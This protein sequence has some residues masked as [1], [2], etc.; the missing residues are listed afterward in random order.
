[1][2]VRPVRSVAI[3]NPLA[4]F[5]INQYSHELAEALGG[6]G[7]RTAYY[8]GSAAGLPYPRNYRRI[9]GLGSVLLKQGYWFG[10]EAPPDGPDPSCSRPAADWVSEA[11]STLG[12]DSARKSWHAPQSAWRGLILTAELALHLRL[13]GFDAVVTQWP[14]MDCYRSF[15]TACRRLGLFLA[16]MVHNVV[17]H[18][19]GRQGTG[20]EEAFQGSHMLLTTSEWGRRQLCALHPELAGRIGVSRI[21]LYTMY[22]RFAD[23]RD[24]VRRQLRVDPGDPLILFCGA[25]RPYKNLDG[26]LD[27]MPSELLRHAT[28][29]VAGVESHYPDLD[30]HDPLG[31][32]RRRANEL[33]ISH[34]LRLIPRHTTNSELA[35]L[36]EASD[37]VALPYLKEYTS[38]SAV[39]PLAMSFGKF[40]VAT[41]TSGFDEYLAQY[42]RSILLSDTSAGTIGSGLVAAAER[43]SPA[44]AEGPFLPDLQWPA[45]ARQLVADI[46]SAR[47]ANTGDWA[48]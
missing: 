36:L 12:P 44:P 8:T 31:R 33:G 5:G 32:A 11:M 48:C 17:P 18:E 42:P 15:W 47:A 27:A 24:R 23:V 3:V 1:V 41:N 20:S 38:G 45:I 34:R 21:G 14:A 40:V 2:S 7:I 30:P 22:P 4:D 35:E 29:V 25:I 39:L 26:I 37:I 16:H 46:Q 43:L 19:K 28:L 13:S 9:P 10:A 6:I